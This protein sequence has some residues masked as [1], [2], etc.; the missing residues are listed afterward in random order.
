MTANESEWSRSSMRVSV[1]A[2]SDGPC[3][4]GCR[5][6]TAIERIAGPIEYVSTGSGADV[7]LQATPLPVVELGS[8]LQSIAGTAALRRPE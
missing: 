8:L 5:Y 1:R 2:Q 6:I 4:A 3:P 7:V